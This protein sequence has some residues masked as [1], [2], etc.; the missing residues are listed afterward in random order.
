MPRYAQKQHFELQV[1]VVSIFNINGFREQI[2]SSLRRDNQPA[3]WLKMFLAP[4]I[5]NNLT[6]RL[7][8]L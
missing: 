7:I 4:V 6:I 1:L 8:G 3:P 5:E 2:A